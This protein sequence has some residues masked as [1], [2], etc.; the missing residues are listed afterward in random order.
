MAR[1][2]VRARGSGP[3]VRRGANVALLALAR[4]ECHAR[5]DGELAHTGATFH[6]RR[7]RVDT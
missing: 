4:R 2:E 5:R 7:L 1:R 6:F 3:F